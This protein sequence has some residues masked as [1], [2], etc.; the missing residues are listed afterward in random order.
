MSRTPRASV[1]A[2]AAALCIVA[3]PATASATDTVVVKY[4]EGASSAQR[5]A[6]ADRLDLGRRVSQIR[7]LGGHVVKVDGNARQ[8]ARSLSAHAGSPTPSRCRFRR[9]SG[10]PSAG[11]ERLVDEA[12]GVGV[13]L[14]PNVPNRPV[15]EPFQRLHHLRV[16]RLEPRV[17]DLVLAPDLTHHEL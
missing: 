12:V 5:A 6:L 14:S 8:L 11:V 2:I 3:I 4:R 9:S 1:L 15:V 7:R 17:L 13:V 10:S 16:K